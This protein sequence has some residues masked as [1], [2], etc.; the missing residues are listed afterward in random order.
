M[1]TRPI[2]LPECG[3][4]AAV[5]IEIYSSESLD[6]SAYVC[7]QHTTAASTAIQTTGRTAHPVSL[8]PHIV[9]PC[10][11]L[12]IYPTGNLADPDGMPHPHWCDR[13][14]CGERG[15]HQSVRLPVSGGHPDPAI[16]EVALSRALVGA[17]QPKL[18]VT[19]VDD[20]GQEVV[21]C[22]GQGRVLCYQLR[23]LLDLARTGRPA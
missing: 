19:V 4:P 8:A 10:G 16:V 2:A 7:A 17:A 9:R 21:L 11:H 15:R 5:R 22:L 20:G 23:R 3:A 6:A 14:G 1:G 13:R 12:H 18:S